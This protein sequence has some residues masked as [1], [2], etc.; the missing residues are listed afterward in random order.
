MR[1][2]V[3]NQETVKLLDEED[4]ILT[5]GTCSTIFDSSNSIDLVVYNWKL[6]DAYLLGRGSYNSECST[7]PYCFDKEPSFALRW[8]EGYALEEREAIE[9]ASLFSSA[10]ILEELQADKRILEKELGKSI[11]HNNLYM[12]YIQR[13]V[14]MIGCFSLNFPIFRRKKRVKFISE[15]M[16][17]DYRQLKIETQA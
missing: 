14:Y 6:S 9:E 15:S 17:R 10:K 7:N 16:E 1:C 12:G 5:C 8:D 4:G 13:W 2:N 11:H 3:C